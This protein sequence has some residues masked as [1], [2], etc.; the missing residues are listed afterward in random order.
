MLLIINECL[1]NAVFEDEEEEIER[2]MHMNIDHV[3]VGR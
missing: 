2:G 1:C 3:H